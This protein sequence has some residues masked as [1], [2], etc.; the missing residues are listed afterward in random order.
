M[1][2]HHIQ[3]KTSTVLEMLGTKAET[4]QLELMFGL[5]GAEIREQCEELIRRGKV[6][7]P[8][9]GCDTTDPAGECLG[10]PAKVK[11]SL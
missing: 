2:R 3:M 1:S 9:Q 10:H 8:T 7:L 11:A 4:K 5:S 6:Y